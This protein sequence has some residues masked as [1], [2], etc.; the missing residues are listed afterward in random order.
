MT[1]F[2]WRILRGHLSCNSINNRAVSAG[3]LAAG[4][5]TCVFAA[6]AWAVGNGRAD[7]F[8]NQFFL[9]M[10]HS[11]DAPSDQ[12]IQDLSRD[13]T[14]LGSTVVLTFITIGAATYLLVERKFG[15]AVLLLV[16]VGGGVILGGLLK[17]H[18]ERPRPP[19]IPPCA[20]LDTWS[21]PSGHAMMSAIVYMVVATLL[22]REQPHL[23][24]RIYFFTVAITL[25][26]GVGL[27]RI[28]LGV[29]WPMDVL[30]GW[31]IG[32]AWVIFCCTVAYWIECAFTAKQTAL[33]ARRDIP[34]VS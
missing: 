13:V 14:A 2:N 32:T 26:V 24:A 19:E 4:A 28:S 18:F 11:L 34:P 15:P 3:L 1:L 16:S 20:D 21:F 23:R 7:A 31:T 33:S 30:G 8:D 10:R 25:T 5:L 6:V 29:H 12:W 22:L 17:V 9:I 27:S